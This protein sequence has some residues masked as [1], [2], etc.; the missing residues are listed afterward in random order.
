MSR[1]RNKRRRYI[2]RRI[3]REGKGNNGRR[4]RR[5]NYWRGNRDC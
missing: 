4:R 2:S 1:K 5:N 3:S